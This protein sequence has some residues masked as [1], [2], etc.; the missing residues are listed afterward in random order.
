M[1]GSKIYNGLNALNSYLFG[2]CAYA[3]NLLA[4]FKGGAYVCFGGFVTLKAGKQSKIS[5]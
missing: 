4:Y 3:R 1:P 2:N 5:S